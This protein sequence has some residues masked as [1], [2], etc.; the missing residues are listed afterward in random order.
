MKNSIGEICEYRCIANNIGYEVERNS[1]GSILILKAYL[2]PKFFTSSTQL[3]SDS[4][5][6]DMVYMAIT[7]FIDELDEE[8]TS[9][10]KSYFNRI[11]NKSVDKE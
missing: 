5:Y 7:K 8:K 4:D 1:R 10:L 2:G 9:L 3:S 11:F 6:L